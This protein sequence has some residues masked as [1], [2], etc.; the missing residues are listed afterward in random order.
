MDASEPTCEMESSRLC[1]ST[2][3]DLILIGGGEHARVV[4]EAAMS[5]PEQWRVIGFVDNQPCPET[6][7]RLGIRAFVSD[8]EAMS[9]TANAWFILGIGRIRSAELRRKLVARYS[10]AGA[11][12]A[13]VVHATAWVSPSAAIAPGVIVFAGAV[14]QT[15]AS[16]GMH[17][18]VNTGA[19]IEHDVTVGDFTLVAPGSAVGGGTVIGPDGYLGLGCSVRDHLQIG[20][21]V[22]VGMGA[23]V[24]RSIQ[25]G[26]T[27]AGV[28]AREWKV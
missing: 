12:W 19:I 16:L 22:T 18:V 10:A 11:R 27:V 25:N 1:M 17:T 3:R 15:G 6:E 14:V 9:E 5:R 20:D 2:P 23:V 8:E 24:T 26:L 28:P 4:A 21:G 7:R 13:T